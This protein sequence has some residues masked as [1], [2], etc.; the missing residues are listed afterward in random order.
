MDAPSPRS[1]I[2]DLLST[3]RHGSMPVAAL[4][5]AGEVFGLASGTLRVALARLLAS[6]R[7]E[8]DE[9]GRYHLGPRAAPMLGA[10]GRWRKLEEQRVA[11]D[12]RWWGVQQSR[13]I[14]RNGRRAHEQSLRLHGFR[15]LTRELSLRPANRRGGTPA[16]RS[17]LTELGLDS[18]AFTFTLDEL[19]AATEARARELWQPEP[20]LASYRASLAQ[21][22]T[23]AA[24]LASLSEPEAM[25]ESFLLGGRVIQ[26]LVL[27]PL[28][29]DEIVDP[30]D[31]DALVASMRRYDRLGRTAWAG[32]LARHAVPHIATPA[33]SG[34]A[35]RSA[36]LDAA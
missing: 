17:G 36:R 11:W 3:L 20:L 16:L 2:L 1:L 21:V 18:G 24:R 25:R 19:D 15:A 23:S 9:R 28:L 13:P 12:G 35:Q 10:V 8:R 33:D 4:L 7:V 31:R 14:P 5:E 29:P 30:T 26:Q 27:D 32:L 6:Q 34:F 22:E